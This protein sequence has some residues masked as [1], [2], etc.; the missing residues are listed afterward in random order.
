[1]LDEEPAHRGSLVRVERRQQFQHLAPEARDEAR[2][3][4]ALGDRLQMCPRCRFV[5]RSS[6]M[7][8]RRQVLV[9][10]LVPFD[11]GQERT[12]PLGPR[13]G[14]GVELQ[15]MVSHVRQL[16]HA[17]DP[18]G[19]VAGASRDA[20][21]KRVARVQPP[22]LRP[23]LLGHGCVLGPRDDRCEHAVDVEEQP[24]A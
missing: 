13:V 17:D 10:E 9:L 4:G 22:Q 5:C 8:R 7:Q 19:V 21:D 14:L 20:G 11:S 3:L 12:Q 6:V 24:C 15:P 16:R 23:R 18:A 1:M 2:S